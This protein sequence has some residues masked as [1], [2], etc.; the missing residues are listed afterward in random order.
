MI[1]RETE[2]GDTQDVLD[3]ERRAFGRGDEAELTRAL[4]EDQTSEPRLSLIALAGDRPVGHILFTRAGI[5]GFADIK[6]TIL[7]PLAVIP[8]AQ[9]RG[10][11]SRLV[12]EGLRRLVAN[13]VELAFV[14]GHPDYYPRFGFEPAIPHGFEPPFPLAEKDVAAWMVLPLRGGVAG[15]VSGR[16]SCADTLNVPE[17]WRE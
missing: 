5:E 6:A 10:I 15:S 4:L 1:I 2:A 12:V 16:V 11:G 17:H 3:V 8:E 13:G 14:L 7:A 9:D